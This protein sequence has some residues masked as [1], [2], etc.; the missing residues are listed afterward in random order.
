MWYLGRDPADARGPSHVDV[1]PGMGRLS[2]RD[3]RSEAPEAGVG[4]GMVWPGPRSRGSGRSR[5]EPPLHS[6]KIT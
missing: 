1:G 2:W 4:T 5:L 6:S 3:P